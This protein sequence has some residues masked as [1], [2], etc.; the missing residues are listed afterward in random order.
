[1]IWLW[2]GDHR[3]SRNAGP[4]PGRP[5]HKAGQ[6]VSLALPRS[7]V[8]IGLMGAGKTA[9]GRRLATHLG[10]PFV[11]ADHEIEQAAGLTIEDIFETYGEPAFRDVERRVIA[12]LLGG[13]IQ[14]VSTGG[15][16][17]M[18]MD[19]RALVAERG[20]S[21]WLR[22]NLDLLVART[23]R[24]G[25]RPLLK[26]GNRREILDGLMKQR[27]PVYAR[28]DITVDSRD[29][30]PDETV[31]A[32]LAALAGYLDHRNDAADGR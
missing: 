29:G 9:I 1:M 15:G 24:R 12:R 31:E 17:Y 32:A 16:A 21:L 28:A 13:D 14:V 19:T 27:Y 18:D 6:P 25:N 26:R 4:I 3:I 5:R 30:P 10:L 22:A 8:L 11:D 7:L 2:R 23:G 20:I